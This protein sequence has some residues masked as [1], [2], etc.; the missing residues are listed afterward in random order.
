M[1]KM[2]LI[3]LAIVFVGCSEDNKTAI[4]VDTIEEVP[5]EQSQKQAEQEVVAVVEVVEVVEVVARTGEDIFKSCSGCH[6]ADAS[7]KAL[8]KSQVIKGWSSEKI[9][10]AL[11]GYKAGT[12]G[13]ATKAVMQGQAAA[14][15]EEDMKLLAD[16]ISKL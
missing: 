12:Y 3:I 15:S 9:I 13:G 10:D 16:Y 14:L 4:K 7:K 1:K 6:G 5:K 11:N 2:I 8:G